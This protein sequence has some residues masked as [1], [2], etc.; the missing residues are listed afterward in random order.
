MAF[1]AHRAIA[2]GYRD[3][4]GERRSLFEASTDGTPRLVLSLL[5]RQDEEAVSARS[6]VR[7]MA[8][9]LPALSSEQIQLV[10]SWIAQGRPR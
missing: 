2:S 6:D 3:E 9:G 10:D 8:L 5:A 4:S 7:G 1:S